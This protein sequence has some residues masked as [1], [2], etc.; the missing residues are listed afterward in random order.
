MYGYQNTLYIKQISKDRLLGAKNE[1]DLLQ[2]IKNNFGMDIKK[3]D[4][5]FSRY[6]FYD[7]DTRIELKT[8][9]NSIN[10]YPKTMI[11]QNK[12]D[13][14]LKRSIKKKCIILYKYPEGLFKIQIDYDNIYKLDQNRTGGRRDRGINEI[15]K[16]GYCY[17]DIKYLEKV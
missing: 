1:L 12:I 9:R 4:G 3:T 13:Y 14:L 15:K 7:D 17:I 5:F 6:D 2:T 10:K 8:M 11:G 16:G